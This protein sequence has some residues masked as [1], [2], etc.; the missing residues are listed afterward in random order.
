[1]RN[2]I[3]AFIIQFITFSGY[4]QDKKSK[5]EWSGTL[6]GAMIPLPAT[7]FGIQPGAIYKFSDRLSWLSELTFRVGN[8]DTK[9]SMAF[10][11]KYFR[12]KQELR[13]HFNYFWFRKLSESYIGLQTAYSFR[14]F[15]DFT[16]FYYDG[17]RN[18][19]VYYFDK[20]IVKSPVISLTLQFGSIYPICD[21]V[22]LD[23]FCGIGARFINT[24]IKD[25][26]NPSSGGRIWEKAGLAIT[27]AYRYPGWEERLNLNAGLRIIYLFN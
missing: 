5:G 27:P 8:K 21:K 15:T 11:K 4:S 10:N 14:S 9:D 2:F 12:V 7:T 18:D 26:V 3:L 16:G 23:V 17:L 1:M 24:H 13:Y 22:S 6:T 25:I 19:S 20:A